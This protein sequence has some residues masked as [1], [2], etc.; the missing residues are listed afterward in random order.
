MNLRSWIEQHNIDR[1]EFAMRV[2]I[3]KESVDNYVKRK[4][5][6][7]EYVA[8]VIE[9]ITNGDVTQHEL[10][11]PFDYPV[12]HPEDLADMIPQRYRVSQK[13]YTLTPQERAQYLPYTFI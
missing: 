6:P 4:N 2:G 1:R 10:T 8:A 11:H 5:R 12:S 9:F 13:L 7:R 3:S